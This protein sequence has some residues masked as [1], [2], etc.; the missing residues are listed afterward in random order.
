M[1]ARSQPRAGSC[2][3]VGQA[4]TP[5]RARMPQRR[6]AGEGFRPWRTPALRSPPLLPQPPLA[7]PPSSGD[8]C[9]MHMAYGRTRLVSQD[10]PAHPLCANATGCFHL[11]LRMVSPCKKKHP[12]PKSTAVVRF[13]PCSAGTCRCS[14]RARPRVARARVRRAAHPELLHAVVDTALVLVDVGPRVARRAEGWHVALRRLRDAVEL[15]EH[16]C[17]HTPHA[18]HSVT[19]RERLH[20]AP[21]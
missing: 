21:S 11:R 3:H 9:A 6:V 16:G 8:V 5:P 4:K 2:E 17:T 7:G 13:P 14:A 10:A 19:L 18:A 1:I 12:R 20:R 15:E